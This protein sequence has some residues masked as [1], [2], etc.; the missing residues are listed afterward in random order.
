MR[1]AL[2]LGSRGAPADGAGRRRRRRALM[3]RLI[4]KAGVIIYVPKAIPPT[5]TGV[6]GGGLVLDD[7]GHPLLS[8][9]ARCASF[10]LFVR[11]APDRRSRLAHG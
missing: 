10:T 6:C 4:L 8:G 7:G 9:S 5:R 11:R 1:A 3:P 2:G